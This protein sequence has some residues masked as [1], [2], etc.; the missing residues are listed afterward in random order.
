MA[1]SSEDKWRSLIATQGRRG[2]SVREFAESHGIAP[3]TMYWWRCRLR[4]R[5]SALVPVSVVDRED[6]SVIRSTARE[7]FELTCGSMKLRIPPDF[8][9]HEIRRLVRA[10][11]C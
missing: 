9:E 7:A 11:R 3:V 6:D 4:D 8:D 10:L 5:P 2:L 1:K